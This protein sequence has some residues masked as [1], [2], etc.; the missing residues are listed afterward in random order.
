M[1]HACLPTLQRTGHSREALHGC[2]CC[3]PACKSMQPR[4]LLLLLQLLYEHSH[5]ACRMSAPHSMHH[6]QLQSNCSNCCMPADEKR[7]A[8]GHVATQCVRS[9]VA[10]V[11]CVTC[12]CVSLCAGAAHWLQT[13]QG[14]E[15]H[16]QSLQ[17]HTQ[18]KAH[19]PAA[20]AAL[21]ATAAAVL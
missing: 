1:G 7:C 4:L 18:S 9:C 20:A 6:Q 5:L 12:A 19:S 17:Q 2:A 16:L 3:C 10:C 15:Q 8:A 14:N 13:A 11:I 21:A